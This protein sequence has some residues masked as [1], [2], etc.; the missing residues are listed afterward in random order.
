[1]HECTSTVPL[2]KP[3]QVLQL[4][5]SAMKHERASRWRKRAQE[6]DM[7]LLLASGHVNS[8]AVE[9]S[10]GR[11]VENVFLL[12]QLDLALQRSILCAHKFEHKSERNTC[13]D[14]DVHTQW[15]M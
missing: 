5:L 8:N 9:G 2:H 1:M 7:N 10:Q 11:G 6:K 13:G 15:H 4:H 12:C 14:A 3:E